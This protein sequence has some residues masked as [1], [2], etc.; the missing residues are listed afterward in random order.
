MIPEK[1]RWFAEARFGMFIHFGPYAAYG[2]GEQV[3]FRE[4]LDQREYVEAATR[5][6]PR[7]FDAKAWAR[8]AKDAGMRYCVLTSRHHDGYCLWDSKQTDYTSASL[9][10]QRDIVGEYVKAVRA[11]GLRVGLYYSLAD[12]RIPA[13]WAGPTH[14]PDGWAKFRGYVHKQLEELL[15]N[16]GRI[17]VLWFDGAWPQ[18]ANDWGGEEIIAMARRLQPNILINNR[19]GPVVGETGV[20][21]SKRQLGDFGTPEH[22]ITAETGRMWESCQVSTWRLWGY[23]IGERWRP[24]DL[25]LDFLCEAAS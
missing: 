25:L 17:D 8:V 14:D 13:Y 10:P 2:R 23:T 15:T 11:A 3:L 1:W 21:G 22:H 4:H 6:N 7:R 5:W 9:A 20:A 12:W 19:L 24:T 16:Y 18:T